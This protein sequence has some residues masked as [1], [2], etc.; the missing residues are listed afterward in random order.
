MKTEIKLVE[1][2]TESL[3]ANVLDQVFKGCQINKQVRLQIGL[4]VPKTAIVDYMVE[5]RFGKLIVEFNGN[6]HYQ[7]GVQQ[8]RDYL[9]RDYCSLNNI[10]LVEI[11]YFIQLDSYTVGMFFPNNVI[12]EY[13]DNFEISTTFPHGFI[14]PKCVLPCDFNIEGWDRFVSDYA[15]CLSGYNEDCE[16]RDVMQQIYVSLEDKINNSKFK[17]P[18]M[19]LGCMNDLTGRLPDTFLEHY[20]T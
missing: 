7:K 10:M 18:I 13:F 8:H 20:P 9:L 17:D 14:D 5:T 6:F 2:L 11:P 1:Y 12:S 16:M 4:T 3:L 15:Y 19:V